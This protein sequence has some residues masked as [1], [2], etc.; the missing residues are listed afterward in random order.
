MR[1]A[2]AYRLSA[3]SVLSGVRMIP[4]FG[5]HTVSRNGRAIVFVTGGDRSV[6]RRPGSVTRCGPP[7]TSRPMSSWTSPMSPSSAPPGSAPWSRRTKRGRW[8]PVVGG[9]RPAVAAADV[10]DRRAWQPTLGSDTR[11]DLDAGH[12]SGWRPWMTDNRREEGAP[13][14]EIVELGPWAGI[15]TDNA[16]Y[17]LEMSGRAPLYGSLADAMKAAGDPASA[18]A[19]SSGTPQRVEVDAP[20]TPVCRSA[21]KSI[22]WRLAGEAV[23][24]PKAGPDGSCQGPGLRV[25]KRVPPRGNLLL[26]PA[27][28]TLAPSRSTP[29]AADGWR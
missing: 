17:L 26:R 8:L 18:M 29:V 21:V 22:G 4:D 3:V 15:G 12:R 14:A 27:R 6:R 24:Q 9:R 1:K 7:R 10:R 2:L 20:G 5:V 13:L 25:V 19:R 23:L 28:G 16:H 11:A